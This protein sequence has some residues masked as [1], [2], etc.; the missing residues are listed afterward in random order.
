[1]IY[2]Y[3]KICIYDKREDIVN[4]FMKLYLSQIKL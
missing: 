2:L 3:Y 1:M 4:I